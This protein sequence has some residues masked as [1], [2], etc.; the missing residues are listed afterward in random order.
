VFGVPDAK[1]T[2]QILQKYTKY[3][4]NDI[5]NPNIILLP[6]TGTCLLELIEN[7]AI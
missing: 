6:H 1:M 4:K 5:A 3:Y 2:L 7:C